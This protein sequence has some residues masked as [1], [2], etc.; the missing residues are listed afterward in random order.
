[1]PL[2]AV[3]MPP[4]VIIVFRGFSDIV[5]MKIVDPKQ[6]YGWITSIASIWQNENET[7]F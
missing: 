4:N 2:L 6:V 7:S 3:K 5:N 1:M